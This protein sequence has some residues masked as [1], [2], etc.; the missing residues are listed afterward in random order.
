[1]C[2]IHTYGNVF[3]GFTVWD[4]HTYGH[5]FLGFTMWD[6]HT[7]R[8]DWVSMPRRIAHGPSL[9]PMWAYPQRFLGHVRRTPY[10][11]HSLGD[12]SKCHRGKG[13]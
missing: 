2:D 11:T 4:V 3:L 12:G 6:V 9:G 7:Y 8:N 13:F 5:V 1:M 10:R